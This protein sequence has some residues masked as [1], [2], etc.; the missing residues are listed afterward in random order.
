M[1][2]LFTQLSRYLAQTETFWRFEPFHV[3]LASSSPWRVQNSRL[4]QWLNGLS[5]LQITQFKQHPELLVKSVA[6]FIDDL[7]VMHQLISESLTDHLITKEDSK[8]SRLNLYQGVPGRK[9][10]QI[11]ALGQYV[12]HKNQATSWLEWCAG[13]GYLGRFLANNSLYPVI[14]FEYQ[15]SLCIAGQADAQRLELAMNFVQGD[16]FDVRHRDLF[17]PDQHVVA[18]HACGDL[19][20]QMVK[21]V[22]DM[23]V[24]NVSFAPCCYHLTQTSHYQPLSILGKQMDLLLSQSELRIPVQETVT[25]G[26]RVKRQ[27]F[28]EMTYRLGWDELLRNELGFTNYQPT[29]SIKK[30][31]LSEGFQAFCYWAS[32]KKRIDLPSIDF[33]KYEQ[34]GVERFWRMEKLSLVQQVFRRLLEMWLILDKAIFLQ[35]HGYQVSIGEFCSREVTPRNIVVYAQRT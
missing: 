10:E 23:S 14:S 32:E 17:K 13:K 21:H 2:T 3:S 33:T 22:V 8:H 26:E 15:N 34:Q 28:L 31:Q 12:V 18:L 19:H 6:P 5:L 25:G 20:V 7:S 4:D 24:K 27:R 9:L 30:S 1:Q 29:P 11:K 16:A 35:Q